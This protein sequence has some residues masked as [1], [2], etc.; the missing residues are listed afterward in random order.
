MSSVPILATY[1]PRKVDKKSWGDGPWLSEPDIVFW[2]D[3][4]TGLPCLI[5]RH[6]EFGSLNGYVGVGQDHRLY[7]SHEDDVN[8]SVHCGLTFHGQAL[9][10]DNRLEELRAPIMGENIWWF[11]FD[12]SH[13]GDFAPGLR[14]QLDRYGSLARYDHEQYKTLEYVRDQVL[15][16]AKGIAECGKEDTSLVLMSASENRMSL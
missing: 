11:G 1:H 3:E 4:S 13:Y 6:T 7:G 10:L 14:A 2:M 15:Q 8:A 12:T 16:L 5:I 9:T